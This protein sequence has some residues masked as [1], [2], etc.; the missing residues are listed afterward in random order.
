MA[1]IVLR[2]IVP[3]DSPANIAKRKLGRGNYNHIINIAINDLEK[4]YVHAVQ[5]IGGKIAKGA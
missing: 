4:E 3:T 1:W 5:D 2:A